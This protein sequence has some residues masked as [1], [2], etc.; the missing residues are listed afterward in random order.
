MSL[1]LFHEWAQKEERREKGQQGA[2][3]ENKGIFIFSL[4]QALMASS[5]IGFFG[6][7][8]QH[9]G[10]AGEKF[11]FLISIFIKSWEVFYF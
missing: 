2:E 3:R 9:M 4:A 1:S 11:K 6:N 7:K 8:L 10:N 5:W